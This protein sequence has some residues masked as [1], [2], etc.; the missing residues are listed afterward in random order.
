MHV[1]PT[2]S[3]ESTRLDTL[4]ALHILD[5]LP[6]ERFDR[7]TRLAKRLFSVPIALVSLVDADR[8]WFKSCAGDDSDETSRDEAFCAHVVHDCEPMVVPDTL[9][10]D[11]FADNPM[12]ID[13]PRIRFYVGYPL[14]LDDG[15]R[16]PGAV[17]DV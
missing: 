5:T 12:V 16:R 15:S 17:H 4:R 10:D 1:P 2:P 14:V 11:R 7:L 9:L 13:E 8:Q 3:N 6:E